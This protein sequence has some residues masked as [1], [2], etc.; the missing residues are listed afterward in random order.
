MD[1][2]KQEIQ[3]VMI[4]HENLHNYLLRRKRKTILHSN[5]RKLSTTN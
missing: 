3:L 1:S 4:R 5:T 2:T